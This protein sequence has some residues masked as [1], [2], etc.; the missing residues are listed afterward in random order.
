MLH[1]DAGHS[2]LSPELEYEAVAALVEV[3]IPCRLELGFEPVIVAIPDHNNSCVALFLRGIVG[4]LVS[5]VVA[6]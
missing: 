5:V 2:H 6:R 1:P 3:F 4:D